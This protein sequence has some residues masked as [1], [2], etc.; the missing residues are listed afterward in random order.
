M[1]CFLWVLHLALVIYFFS[2]FDFQKKSKCLFNRL[3]RVIEYALCT[4]LPS[5][6]KNNPNLFYSIIVGISLFLTGLVSWGFVCFCLCLYCLFV[7]L[8]SLNEIWIRFCASKVQKNL[9]NFCQLQL[10]GYWDS[11]LEWWPWCYLSTAQQ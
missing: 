1:L 5:K 2:G 6:M 3:P 10:I 4:H 9:L 8:F 11:E 7:C